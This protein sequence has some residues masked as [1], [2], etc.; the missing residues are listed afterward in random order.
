MTYLSLFELV[1]QLT[2]LV[3]LVTFRD[4]V[5]T[6]LHIGEPAGAATLTAVLLV[7]CDAAGT[8]PA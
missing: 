1:F 8:I 5:A 2:R 6:G 4:H 3:S 7:T